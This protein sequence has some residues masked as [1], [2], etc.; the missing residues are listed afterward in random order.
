MRSFCLISYVFHE[1]MHNPLKQ[2]TPDV[3]IIHLLL[4]SRG[5]ELFFF[6]FFFNKFNL[7]ENKPAHCAER[8]AR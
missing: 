6:S 4:G 1:E 5:K 7:I 3:P 8:R 2:N